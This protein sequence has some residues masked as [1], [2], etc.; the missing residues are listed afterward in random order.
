MHGVKQRN[1]DVAR[2]N[3]GHGEGRTDICEVEHWRGVQ[4]GVPLRITG[5][6]N[7]IDGIR[8][9]VLMRKHHAFGASGGAAGVIEAGEFVIIHFLVNALHHV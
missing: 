1:E 5:G 7:D 6:H 2:T 8:H 9:H 4:V 3:H